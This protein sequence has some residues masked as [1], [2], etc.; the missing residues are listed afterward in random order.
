MD[1]DSLNS[2]ANRA[3][4]DILRNFWEGGAQTGRLKPCCELVV[5]E[6]G[7]AVLMMETCYEATK[8]P[9]I[10]VRLNAEWKALQER[11]KDEE[12]TAPHSPCNPA[13]DDAAW[14]AMTLMTLYLFTGD[15]KARNMAAMTVKRS[16]NFWKDGSTA[17][18]IWYRFGDD[19][20]LGQYGWAKSVY[21]AGLILTALEYHQMTKGTPEEDPNLLQETMDLYNWVEQYLRRDSCKEF[22]GVPSYC[23]DQLYFT[24]FIDNRQTG[25]FK[26]A[27]VEDPQ[28][29]FEANSC[30]SLF[31]NTAMAAINSI[32][33]S[34]TNQEIFR[35]KAVKTANALVSSPYNNRGILLNDR[36][37][38]TNTAFMRYFVNWVLPLDGVNPEV[39]RI[40]KN[41]GIKVALDCR[42]PEGYYRPE[43][44]GGDRWTR[45]T[46]H[47][48]EWQLKTSATSAHMIMAAAL[49]ESRKM[50]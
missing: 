38:W 12:M 8:N 2:L 30:S 34:M 16:Y 15:I 42:T 48:K 19:G 50:Q 17:N 3:L 24:D 28:R 11:F 37:A 32:L 14:T 36:D 25:E 6:L 27:G 4:E 21:C 44:S 23:D 7:M 22:R 35:E 46:S 45:G 39:A 47:T 33:Y 43:W 31:G 5:W 10:P 41:T 40:I 49:I 29:I 20:T 1:K 9:E 13:C 26:P 18:G